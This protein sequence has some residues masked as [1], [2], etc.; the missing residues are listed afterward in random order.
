MVYRKEE[1]VINPT[2]KCPCKNKCVQ[3]NGWGGWVWVRGAVIAV[4]L[5]SLAAMGSL[6]PVLPFKLLCN[7]C[8]E[9]MQQSRT[10][11]TWPWVLVC[12][13]GRLWG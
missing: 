6:M 3:G 2:R 1:L 5:A 7:T 4:A 12:R 8:A 13:M 10:L 9:C 11:Q